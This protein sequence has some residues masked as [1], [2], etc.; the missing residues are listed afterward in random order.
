MANDDEDST[1]ALYKER[2]PK[3]LEGTY[4]VCIYACMDPE[5][6]TSEVRVSAAKMLWYV[7]HLIPTD[8]YNLVVC[9]YKRDFFD[10]LSVLLKRPKID[11][12]K[13]SEY[14]VR[15]KQ[16]ADTAAEFYKFVIDH[17]GLYPVDIEKLKEWWGHTYWRFLHLTSIL[18][19]NDKELLVAFASILIN[20]SLILVCGMCQENY[21]KLEPIMA[22][23]YPMLL[24]SDPV[25]RIYDLHNKV[26]L[27]KIHPTKEFAFDDFLRLY[28]LRV[29][30]EQH[31]SL[32]AIVQVP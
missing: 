21:D 11:G 25:T 17:Y 15:I 18:A 29:L 7:V 23:T 32:S 13:V 14:F 28:N 20:L 26:N 27:H 5:R 8:L 2:T 6:L 4:R 10:M 30:S 9:D 16:D 1:L 19:Q 3:R 22:I 24:T 31:Q 12:D